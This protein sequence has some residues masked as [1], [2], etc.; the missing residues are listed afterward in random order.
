[1]QGNEHEQVLSF[2]I[3]SQDVWNQFLRMGEYF[4]DR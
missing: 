4:Q 1:M 2:K 3:H